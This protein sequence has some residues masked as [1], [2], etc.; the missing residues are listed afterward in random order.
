MSLR[1]G[2]LSPCRC[3]VAA[4]APSRWCNGREVS[5]FAQSVNGSAM[6]AAIADSP[7]ASS[8]H[9][10]HDARPLAGLT[11]LVLATCAFPAFC[12][13]RFHAS[14]RARPW[15]LEIRNSPFLLQPRSKN[16]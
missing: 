8:N 14:V 15:M 6:G 11:S 2:R 10:S 3:G 1:P 5:G 13:S 16:H 12:L 7:V 9:I 4:L